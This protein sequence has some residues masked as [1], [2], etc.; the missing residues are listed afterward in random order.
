MIL[1]EIAI[2]LS[3][4]LAASPINSIDTKA[5]LDKRIVYLNALI[6][7]KIISEHAHFRDFR[8]FIANLTT[9]L[10]ALSKKVE[11]E[12]S[13]VSLLD[14][15]Q[16]IREKIIS[17]MVRNQFQWLYCL[18]NNSN[19]AG[20]YV[21][22]ALSLHAPFT[23]RQ[24]FQQGILGDWIK[25]SLLGLGIKGETFEIHTFMDFASIDNLFAQDLPRYPDQLDESGLWS[26]LTMNKVE[27]H[28]FLQHL[29][30][31]IRSLYEL[32]LVS[33]YFN[34]LEEVIQYNGE[35]WLR[36]NRA[37]HE[38]LNLFISILLF[39]QNKLMTETRELHAILV[40]K[41]G[42]NQ[43]SQQAFVK[44]R[45]F[46]E[47][48]EEVNSAI[49]IKTQEIN[50]L[51]QIEPTSDSQLDDLLLELYM[52][53]KQ[54]ADRNGIHHDNQFLVQPPVILQAQ[55]SPN[56]QRQALEQVP[57]VV[58]APQVANEGQDMI[59][60]IAAL[61]LS[62]NEL[63]QRLNALI[64]VG[65]SRRTIHTNLARLP[66]YALFKSY[67]Y[68][69][70]SI[71]P[72]RLREVKEYENGNF[73]SSQTNFSSHIMNRLKESF[74]SFYQSYLNSSRFVLWFYIK[75]GKIDVFHTMYHKV[76]AIFSL[77]S[78]QSQN[79]L[80]EDQ[81][82]DI[83]LVEVLLVDYL[84]KFCRDVIQSDN[85]LQYLSSLENLPNIYVNPNDDNA[86][87][88]VFSGGNL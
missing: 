65:S 9:Q 41:P 73:I 10:K 28:G 26:H 32:A 66:N 11:F 17:G 58:V 79:N 3:V 63:Q 8:D 24:I 35:D 88:I 80:T 27:T 81:T 37:G 52:Q 67:L 54:Y 12:A 34:F 76:N 78:Q 49:T 16:N 1:A 70:S 72:A 44:A 19:E 23:D 30:Q 61:E 43:Q 5:M 18:L 15:I 71:M 47:C 13:K 77:I 38:V 20:L 39:A 46:F 21:F 4:T 36:I 2:W 59:F 57:E 7:Q 75:S 50:E 69:E 86:L 53:L 84:Y 25:K 48:L 74:L 68:Q 51:M 56:Q 64:G 87:E 82:L 83:R 42:R 45:G 31:I 6:S 85:L 40:A 62:A 33:Q 29:R 14:K 60:S 55:A 22:N